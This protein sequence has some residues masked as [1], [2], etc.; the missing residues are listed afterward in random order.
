M[1]FGMQKR[2]CVLFVADRYCSVYRGNADC[3]IPI[4]NALWTRTVTMHA[5]CSDASL[6]CSKIGLDENAY[7]H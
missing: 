1:Q 6:I 7:E 5:H 4:P 2:I 3:Q